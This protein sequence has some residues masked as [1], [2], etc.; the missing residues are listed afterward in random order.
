[1][2]TD[3]RGPASAAPHAYRSPLA[4]T[5]VRVTGDGWTMT[6]SS[7]PCPAVPHD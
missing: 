5:N 2:N 4:E 6:Q 3:M 1:M 7:T